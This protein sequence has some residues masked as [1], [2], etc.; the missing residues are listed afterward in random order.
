MGIILISSGIVLMFS[1]G[2]LKS[3]N[4]AKKIKHLEIF[5]SVKVPTPP[6]T[7]QPPQGQELQKSDYKYAEYVPW[8]L[9]QTPVDSAI[10]IGVATLAFR[11]RLIKPV[12]YKFAYENNAPLFK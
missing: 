4:N 9:K 5:E 6:R 12:D 11:N 2:Y 10:G 3:L 7:T 1:A 8:F